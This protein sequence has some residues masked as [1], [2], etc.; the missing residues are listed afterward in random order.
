MIETTVGVNGQDDK[1]NEL[2]AGTPQDAVDQHL[3]SSADQVHP[4]PKE[5]ENMVK[6]DIG[7]AVAA[8]ADAKETQEARDEMS[9]VSPGELPLLMNRE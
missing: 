4:H 1:S 3:E 9:Q 2:V 5:V 7:E 6:P 8:P